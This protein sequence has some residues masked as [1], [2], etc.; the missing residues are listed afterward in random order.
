M[1][2]SCSP[3]I[4]GSDPANIRWQIVRGDTESLRVEF[5][6]NDESTYFDTSDWEYAATSYDP[7]GDF[8]DELTVTA[9]NGYVDITIPS[10]V[11]ELWGSGY[12]SMAL[13]LPFDLQV[14]ID[15]E[16]VWTPLLG[17]IVV[18]ADI[19]GGL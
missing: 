12:R 6:E 15:G 19:T 1:T 5:L 4:F 18:L 2:S 9:G 11:S 10:E 17:I 14:T 13:E 7:S 8:L 16:T 3:E